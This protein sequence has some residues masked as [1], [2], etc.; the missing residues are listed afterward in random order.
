M[1][2]KVSS[3]LTRYTVH[4]RAWNVPEVDF[5]VTNDP[6]V[7]RRLVLSVRQWHSVRFGTDYGDRG[8]CCHELL[9]ARHSVVDKYAE[10]PYQ[11]LGYR[12]PAQVFADGRSIR[13]LPE[14]AS[15]LSSREVMSDFPAGVSLNLASSLS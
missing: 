9:L 3:Q 14:Q 1:A 8:S 6:A 4:P 5:E 10:R 15:T 13:C 7:Q 2:R 12:N 11:F